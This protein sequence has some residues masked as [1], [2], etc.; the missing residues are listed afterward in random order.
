MKATE[1]I[2]EIMK[3]EGIGVTKLADRLG[4]GKNVISE[5]LRQ[6]N[7]SMEKL[8]EILRVLDYKVVLIP[9]DMVTP[10]SGYEIK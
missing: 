7:I 6:D 1:A 5:R 2:R 9:R 3:E 10:K 8:G 4:K